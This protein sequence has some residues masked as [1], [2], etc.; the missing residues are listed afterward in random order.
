MLLALA[1]L[2]APWFILLT[3]RTHKNTTTPPAPAGPLLSRPGTGHLATPSGGNVVLPLLAGMIIAIAAVLALILLSRRRRRRDHA[4]PGQAPGVTSLAEGLA[5]G[6]AA[7]E[8]GGPPREAIIACY[9]AME[10]G[11][12]TAGSAPAA[13]DT[14]AEVL[15]RATEA[16]IVRSGS[17]EV[18]TGLFRW[19]RYSTEPMTSAEADAAAS[20]LA[21]M[22]ADLE[23]RANVARSADLVTSAEPGSEP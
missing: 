11:F 6:T 21:R 18:L 9:A 10:R 20:A 3:D 19:A 16:G 2:A 7:L 1:M 23:N 22:R 14:P 5:A 12:A 13:A 15:A 8:T 17:A 4:P